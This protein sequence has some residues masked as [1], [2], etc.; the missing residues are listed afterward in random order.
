MPEKKNFDYNTLKKNFQTIQ[1]EYRAI[2]FYHLD[3]DITNFDELDA[4]LSAFKKLGYGG[5][6]PVPVHE[7]QPEFSTE[8]YFDALEHILER[9]KK[10]GMKIIYYDDMDY[11][12]GWAGGELAERYPEALSWILEKHEYMCT[13]GSHMKIKLKQNG[14]TMSL[15]ALE[16][17][18]LDIRD[19]RDYVTDGI[20]EWDVPDG[21]WNV[22]HFVCAPDTESKYVN[23]LN[24]EASCKFVSLTYKRFVDRFASYIGDVCE[25]TFYDD[26]QFRAKNRRMWDPS[27]N[28]IF[29][30]QF[31]FDPSPYYPMLFIERGGHIKALFMN[32][33]AKM[34]C[35]GFFKAVSDFTSAHGLSSTGHVA[36]M[37]STSAPWIF[38]DGMLF[39]KNA[40]ASGLGLSYAYAYGENGLKLASG[41]ADNFDQE[42]VTCEIYGSYAKLDR[43]ILY[44]EAMNAFARGVNFLIP[45]GLWF[46]GK[47]RIPH[48]LS[49]RSSFRDI[50]PEYNDF[51]ARAQTLLRGGCHISDIALLYPIYS[52]QSQSYLYEADVTGVEYPR[53]PF[54]ADYM[55][56]INTLLNYCGKDVTL[57]HPETL[58]NHCHIEDGI[59]YLN[60]KLTPAQF[61]VLI[62][63]GASMISLESL[64]IIKRF[65]DCGGKIIATGDLPFRAF[66]Y[67]RFGD[68]SVDDEVAALIEYIFG[69]QHDRLHDFVEYFR[70]ENEAGGIAYFL[71]ASLTAADETE[72]VPSPFFNAI[73]NSLGVAF[74]VEITNMPKIENSGIL[75]AFLPMY[76]ALGAQN[77]IGTGGFFNYIH[78]RQGNTDIYFISNTTKRDYKG[79]IALLGVMDPEE[80]NPYT[81]KIRRLPSKKVLM[82]GCTYTQIEL[83][84]THDTATFLVAEN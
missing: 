81:G 53:T 4:Q 36:Q 73:L 60:N 43:R 24:Y 7:T 8:R 3:G 6:T 48:N 32:C 78:K 64:R 65:F 80:W 28:E 50:L 47:A 31:G 23:Y 10:L 9:A 5:V 76:L 75:N 33:R 27:F 51:V 57:L 29:E 59:L 30:R 49:H 35:D 2:P 42:T 14:M 22:M 41:A 45:H 61:K 21:N 72:F 11:P 69:V 66:E 52:L 25:M 71:P 16:V 18:T 39:Q 1:N 58:C 74:D 13:E 17:D 54:N 46:S 19:L 84:L 82:N 40:G 34:L 26:I 83:E 62:L 70:N 68:H 38:G 63:P 20:L 44:N 55:N 12:S 15:T 67:P 79:K 37:K 77:G 56:V